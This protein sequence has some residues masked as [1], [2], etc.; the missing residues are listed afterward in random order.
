MT[1]PKKLIQTSVLFFISVFYALHSWSAD[2]VLYHFGEPEEHIASVE[3]IESK[4]PLQAKETVTS[5]EE[6]HIKHL[7]TGYLTEGQLIVSGKH[8]KKI[9]S[10]LS[11]KIPYKFKNNGTVSKVRIKVFTTTSQKG[12]AYIDQIPDDL[13]KT[14]WSD[15]ELVALPLKAR[16]RVK[17]SWKETYEVDTRLPSRSFMTY[18]PANHEYGEHDNGQR[19]LLTLS[20]DLDTSG[21]SCSSTSCTLKPNLSEQFVIDSGMDR[22]LLGM[23][24]HC[25]NSE[26]PIKEFTTTETQYL[27]DMLYLGFIYICLT[28]IYVSQTF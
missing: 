1:A 24:N 17:S 23:S 11:G 12:A 26:C 10:L 22:L 2:K 5:E 14:K 9:R 20:F 6:R 21:G 19:T 8:A 18:Q 3:L 13:L 16:S 4:S 28:A 27:R 25:T 7:C 15:Y